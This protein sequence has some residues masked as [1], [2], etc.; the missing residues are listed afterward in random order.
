MRLFKKTKK[1]RFRY[2]GSNCNH[3]QITYWEYFRWLPPWKLRSLRGFLFFK[4]FCRFVLLGFTWDLKA[5]IFD[6]QGKQL[7]P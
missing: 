5:K 6:Q 2:L 7:Y 1:L 4:S 3:T